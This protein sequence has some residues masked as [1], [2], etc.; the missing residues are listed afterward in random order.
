M[1]IGKNQVERKI[2]LLALHLQGSTCAFNFY[3][4]YYFVC[5]WRNYIKRLEFIHEFN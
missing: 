1:T 4:Y 2:I 5:V 3:F